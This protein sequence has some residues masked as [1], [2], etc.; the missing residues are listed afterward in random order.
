MCHFFLTLLYKMQ[1]F[2][3]PSVL[4]ARAILAARA[5]LV[6]R[7]GIYEADWTE[8]LDRATGQS[9]WTEHDGRRTL[10]MHS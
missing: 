8:Q 5:I 6:A 2:S 4:V 3:A 1:I 10:Y 7:Y 9:S